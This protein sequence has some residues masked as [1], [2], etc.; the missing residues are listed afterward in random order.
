M[1]SSTTL[2]CFRALVCLAM[3]ASV[4]GLICL[5]SFCPNGDQP[6]N[7]YCEG[8]ADVC[9]LVSHSL[10]LQD[11]NTVE[12]GCSY[13]T[14]CSSECVLEPTGIGHVHYCCCTEDF[15]NHVPEETDHLI[16]SLNISTAAPTGPIPTLLS[17]EWSNGYYNLI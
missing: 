3:L 6:C 11:F 10:D 9:H 13:N 17:K 5:S 12:L 15:C 7:D 2:A 14:N 4:N 8:P 1:Q 16:P